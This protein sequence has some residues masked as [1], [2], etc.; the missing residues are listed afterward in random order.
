MPLSVDTLQSLSLS[1][2]RVSDIFYVQY[3]KLNITCSLVPTL[4]PFISNSSAPIA[5]NLFNLSCDY[6]LST[7]V[8][9]NITA[10]ATWTINDIPLNISEDG[11][12]SD[13]VYLIFSPLT[14]SY[15]G[16]YTCTL[17]ITPSSETPH[18]TAQEPVQSSEKGIIVQSKV[19]PILHTLV[20]MPLTSLSHSLLS[21]PTSPLSPL[22]PLSPPT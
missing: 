13:G 9:T 4:T 11:I 8:D 15:T 22:P 1:M 20:H 7:L 14:T 21:L 3:I 17:T 12:S 5:G 19:H 2:F 16:I 18:V 10:T 6:T